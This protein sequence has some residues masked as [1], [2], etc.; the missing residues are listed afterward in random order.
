VNRCSLAVGCRVAL[1]FAAGVILATD[2]AA[3]ANG[4]EVFAHWCSA[5]HAAGAGH[6]G[7]QALEAKYNGA[8]PGELERRTDLTPELVRYFVRHG[9]SVMP[10]F[11]KTEISDEDLSALAAWLARS[12]R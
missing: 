2:R 3:A 6:P 8:E 11:R 7:T 5:C 9:V 12:E 10:F 1:A 4:Q